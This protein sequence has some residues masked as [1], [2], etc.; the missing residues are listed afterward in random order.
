M[1]IV[2]PFCKRESLE[3]KMEN[4]KANRLKLAEHELTERNGDISPATSDF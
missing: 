4:Y 2:K 1:K 3:K